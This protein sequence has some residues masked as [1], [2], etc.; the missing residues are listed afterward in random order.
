MT[1]SDVCIDEC[2]CGVPGP[3]PDGSVVIEVPGADHAESSDTLSE[4]QDQPEDDNWLKEE[5]GE[6]FNFFNHKCLDAILRSTKLSLDLIR[7]R[8]FFQ[9]SVA[10]IKYPMLAGKAGVSR[11]R[12]SVPRARQNDAGN[13]RFRRE[14]M[15]R[16]QL[17]TRR[18]APRA[19]LHSFNGSP[20]SL[21]RC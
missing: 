10:F 5:C 8:V 6:L 11:A 17:G 21:S 14:P 19:P 1:M 20:S 9:Q 12:S 2:V 3:L 7:K 16:A 18:S 15:P 4:S 13:L